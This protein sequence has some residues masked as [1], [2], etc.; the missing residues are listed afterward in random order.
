MKETLK[1][2]QAA[3][4]KKCKV[5]QVRINKETEADILEWLAKGAAG[6]RIKELI[7][8]DIKKNPAR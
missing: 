6:T 8:Q 7:R 4:N 1:K 5:I 2:A 3:Y